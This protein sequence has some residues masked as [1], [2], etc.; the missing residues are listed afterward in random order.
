MIFLLEFVGCQ[1]VQ[2]AVRLHGVVVAPPRLDDHTRLPARSEPFQGQA[3]VAKLAIE[4]LVGAVL[5]RLTGIAQ[6]SGDARLG[7]PLE[8]GVADELR[9]IVRTHKQRRAVLTHEAREYLDDPLRAN[10]TGHI[11][12]QAFTGVLVHHRQ[13][14]DLAAIGSDVKDEVV[15][16]HHVH[17]ERGMGAR[18]SRGD[19]LARR[20]L[21]S[22]R[23]A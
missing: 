22:N 7:D 12:C 18:P 23:P 4:A 15:G 6:R 21:G 1:V 11:N 13:A 3:F 8:D 16:P 9:T 2:A 20:L 10:G 19:A 14:F 17:L 5:P